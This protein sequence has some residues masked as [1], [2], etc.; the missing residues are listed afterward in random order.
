MS[1]S[2]FRLLRRSLVLLTVTLVL[3]SLR[4]LERP[5]FWL[6]AQQSKDNDQPQGI[7]PFLPPLALKQPALA[8]LERV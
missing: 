3:G 5:S 6:P 1:F 8:R 4:A 7:D 2:F